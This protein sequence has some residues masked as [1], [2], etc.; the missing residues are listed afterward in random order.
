MRLFAQFLVKRNYRLSTA[1]MKTC[2]SSLIELPMKSDA[3]NGPR[4][5]QQGASKRT[6]EKEADQISVK[7]SSI[8]L[9]D[10]SELDSYAAA[11]RPTI[12][13][14]C[15][16]ARQNPPDLPTAYD[17]DVGRFVYLTGVK[18]KQ[19]D[20]KNTGHER[21][22]SSRNAATSEILSRG[23]SEP[24]TTETAQSTVWCRRLLLS[25]H[26]I[27]EDPGREHSRG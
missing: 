24:M 16:D 17:S 3:E 7:R 2:C 9:P 5:D 14:T 26:G 18:N 8:P 15:P 6:S 1:T 25:S 23:T 21:T 11:E 27:S 4:T 19:A 22:V 10:F 12:S 13:S 20:K